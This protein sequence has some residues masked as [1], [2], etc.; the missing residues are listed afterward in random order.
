MVAL[1]ITDPDVDAE[2]SESLSRNITAAQQQ[3]PQMI[4]AVEAAV[5]RAPTSHW[6]E[7]ALFPAGNYYWVQLDR[8]RAA[9]LLQTARGKFSDIPQRDV[10]AVARGVDRRPEAP[11]GSRG[12]AAG[13]SAAVSRIAVHA[14]RAVL[15]WPPRRRSGSPP[16]A[17]GYYAKLAER[18]PQNYFETQAAPRR[19]RAGRRAVEESGRARFDSA[20]FR[21][22]EAGW[23]DSARRSGRQARADAL[24]SIAFDASAELELRAGYAATG[25]PRL[26]L[27][28]AQA[29][30]AAGHYG[31]AIVTVRQI[32]PQLESQPFS[33]V[34]RD[35]WLRGLRAAV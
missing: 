18:Y 27:E 24:R 7:S 8:D 2:R 25:E 31:A 19:S 1:Q 16:L 15:A 22:A 35:V 14:R 21:G 34:P 20:R 32:F 4:A 23:T 33:D 3:E 26:L 12:D 17:R 28:A 29:A 11:A 13:A 10:G 5:S 6:A 30:A 9:E